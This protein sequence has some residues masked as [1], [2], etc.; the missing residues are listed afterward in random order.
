MCGV[1]HCRVVVCL[2][3]MYSTC[4]TNKLVDSR[5][6]T[7]TQQPQ[8]QP[9]QANANEGGRW[10]VREVGP[11]HVLVVCVSSLRYVFYKFNFFFLLT[12]STNTDTLTWER[13]G[14]HT[15]RPCHGHHHQLPTLTPSDGDPMSPTNNDDDIVTMSLRLRLALSHRI[16]DIDNLGHLTSPTLTQPCEHLLAGCSQ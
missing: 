7:W 8:H 1:S 15:T 2:Y 6:R 12:F 4:D 10:R 14:P 3:H 5:Q 11:R 13:T 16:S 9:P